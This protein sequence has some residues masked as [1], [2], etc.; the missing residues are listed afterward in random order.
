MDIGIDL[1]TTYSVIA[2]K[3]KV[4]LVDGY[5]AGEY[6]EECDVTQIPTPDGDPTKTDD[7]GEEETPIDEYS[8]PSQ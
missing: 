6:F 2:V 1:G 7:Y 3:G 8:N 4:E 5:P